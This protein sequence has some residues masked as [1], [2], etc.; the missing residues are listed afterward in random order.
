MARESA[1]SER[2]IACEGMFNKLDA[3]HDGFITLDELKALRRKD[4]HKNRHSRGKKAYF[5]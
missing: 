3:N 4:V 1:Q 2:L 5:F